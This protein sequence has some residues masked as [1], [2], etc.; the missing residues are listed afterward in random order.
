MSKMPITFN[1]LEEVAR[2][3][4]HSKAVRKPYFRASKLDKF[5]YE[6]LKLHSGGCSF[7]EIKFW[8]SEKNI[9]VERST[10]QRWISDNEISEKTTLT[11]DVDT[12]TTLK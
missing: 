11:S 4:A 2:L 3:K 12:K 8:L 7:A 10:I 9:V 5:K 1:V 6:I